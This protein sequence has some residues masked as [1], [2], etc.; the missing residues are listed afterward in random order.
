MLSGGFNGE[1]GFGA[2]IEIDGR[3]WLFDTGNRP[4][5]VLQNLRE[6]KLDLNGVPAVIL[7][8]HHRDHTGGLVTLRREAMKTDPKAIAKAYGGRGILHPRRPANDFLLMKSE[9][10]ATGARLEEVSAPAELSP[11]VWLTGPVPRVHNERNWSGNTRIRQD[12]AEGEDTLPEDQAL[13][14][15]TEAGLIVVSG[16]GHAG[17]IN[18]LTYARKVVRQ[19]PIHA[20]IGGFH[21]FDADEAKLRWTAAELAPMQVQYFL[22]AHCTGVE[23]TVRLRE[24]LQIPRERMTIAQVGRVFE[25]GKGIVGGR[26]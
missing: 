16:C 10:E 2:L 17:I 3:R 4:E 23:S 5:T 6:M 7:T 11:G 19:A 18:T 12:G 24:L 26:A 9:Y 25:L 8:H 15:D 21:L 13:V 1:W 20:L 14:I 22:A